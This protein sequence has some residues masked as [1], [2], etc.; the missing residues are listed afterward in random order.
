MVVNLLKEVLEEVN[1][2]KVHLGVEE[3]QWKDRLEVVVSL[4]IHYLVVVEGHCCFHCVIRDRRV[5]A[6]LLIMVRLVEGQLKDLLV[7]EVNQLID[8]LEVVAGLLRDLLVEEEVHYYFHYVIRVLLV[9][10]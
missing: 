8:R 3:D 7:E 2:L 1:L 5:V 6:N 4:L 9:V 10:V